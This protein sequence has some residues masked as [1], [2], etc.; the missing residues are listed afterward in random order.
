[1]DS[2]SALALIADLRSHSSLT[3]APPEVIDSLNNV[4]QY[5]QHHNSIESSQAA[6]G[7][8]TDDSSSQPQASHGIQV[9]HNV[10]ISRKTVL[11]TVYTYDNVDTCVEYPETG[12]T[13]PVGYLFRQSSESWENP[14]SDIGQGIKVCPKINNNI[15]VKAHTSACYSDVQTQ[16]REL[17]SHQTRSTT[18][19]RYIFG[20]TAALISALRILGCRGPM[21][22]RTLD[23][24]DDE[25]D[26][27]EFLADIQVK[28]QRGY[29]PKQPACKGRL[30]LHEY[31]GRFFVQC[32]HYSHKER[33]DHSHMAL[34]GSVNLDYILAFFSNNIARLS[35]IES[36]AAQ[37]GYAFDH[38]DSNGLLYQPMLERCECNV[39]VRY[40]IPCNDY[41]SDCPYILVTIQGTHSHP[42]PLPEKTPLAIKRKIL[43]LLDS[44]QDDLPD[45]T[46]R[47]FLRH[48]VVK[49]YLQATFP[50]ATHPITLADLHVSLA[51][52]AH[53]G[54]Y[55]AAARE[56]YFPHGTGWKGLLHLKEQH[57]K[58]GIMYIRKIL[59]FKA[60][61]FTTGLDENDDESD[62][63]VAN[64]DIR[65][66]SC[67]TP[68]GSRR[69]L[70]AQYIQS[71][72]AFKR[73][74]GFY[75]F[76]IATVDRISNTAVTFCRVYVTSQSAP[77]HCRIFQEVDNIVEEDTGKRL[78][79]RHL[80]AENLDQRD[81]MIL[82][83]TLDQHGGQAKG[84]GLYLRGL[85]QQ[86]PEKHDLHEPSLTI[87]SLDPYQHLRR[88]VRLCYVHALRNIQKC[89]VSD[90]VRTLMRSLLTIRH[91]TWDTTLQS[92]QEQGGKPGKAPPGMV[93][94]WVQDKIRSKFALPAICWEKS[95][96]P[97]DIW[98][99]GDSTSNL[100]ESVHADVNR[101]GTG[102]TLVGGLCKGQSFDTM[103]LKALQTREDYGIRPSYQTG[104]LIDN[105]TKS[106]KR[107]F[108]SHHT[109]LIREDAKIESQNKKLTAVHDAWMKK[110]LAVSSLSRLG[111]SPALERA[112][113]AC[114]KLSA[115]FQAAVVD[116]KALIGSGT[117]KIG[118]LLP[119]MT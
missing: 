112:I 105:A 24:G 75:E 10:R 31:N 76:E 77:T 1:M 90:D 51:N 118:L 12:A 26:V 13:N 71:D 2:S 14:H 69:L 108:S 110:S 66:V 53:L 43:G 103:K 35:E 29:I 104:E 73:V 116:S 113:L 88:L 4:L 23:F 52:R 39:K 98:N 36:A 45:L 67:M 96:I 115:T 22:E 5:F 93:L 42:I 54:A 30:C 97:I 99:A 33:R 107:K 28:M 47:K 91:P 101:E 17:Q 15:K 18:P 25:D 41:R 94:D 83:W 95:F 59:E 46:A 68:E 106:I 55:I 56:L 62:R 64:S 119:R 19:D 57:D 65:L 11:D 102:C 9:R 7:P 48:P 85:A 74:V 109:Q 61:V 32:E 38:R 84:L 117:G 40:Y 81:G 58:R 3:S 114:D 92:I 82:S 6:P 16:C 44:M 49:A 111:P 50:S 80:H 8:P 20:K 34:D 79:W 72:I 21:Y 27:R 87:A 100:I 70:A 37:D 60:S 63:D 86:F 89:N 78:Q